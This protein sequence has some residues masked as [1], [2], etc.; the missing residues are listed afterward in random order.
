M[1][2]IQ[3]GAHTII[4]PKTLASVCLRLSFP[5]AFA[6]RQPDEAGAMVQVCFMENFAFIR[7]GVKAMRYCA[8]DLQQ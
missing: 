6:S 5:H 2:L 1:E 4:P 3:N 7:Y 8:L